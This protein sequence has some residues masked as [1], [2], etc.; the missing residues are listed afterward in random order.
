MSLVTGPA[1]LPGQILLSVLWEISA[2]LTLMKLVE[3]KLVQEPV[4][5]F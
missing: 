4:I 2:W 5:D 3:H 1:W